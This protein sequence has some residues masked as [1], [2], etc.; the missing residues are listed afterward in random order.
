MELHPENL[1]TLKDDMVAFIA[2]HGLRRMPG[3]VGEDVP[4]VVF[5]DEGNPDAWKDFVELAKSSGSLFVTMND[6]VLTKSDLEDLIETLRDDAPKSAESS[7]LDESLLLVNYV[8]RT[9]YLQLGFGYHG[10]LYIYEIS[11][12]WYSRFQRL[13]ASLGMSGNITVDGRDIDE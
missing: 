2:G 3:R 9:G 4:C 6:Y 13:M 10:I 1:V 5:E 11:T 8:G 7:D 12:A